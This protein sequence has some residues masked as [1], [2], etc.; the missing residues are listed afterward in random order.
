MLSASHDREGQPL[1]GHA[2]F[3]SER[4][5]CSGSLSSGT[6]LFSGLKL[7]KVSKMP[8]FGKVLKTGSPDA[9]LKALNGEL[10]LRFMQCLAAEVEASD[11]GLPARI[12]LAQL[13]GVKDA[14]VANLAHVAAEHARLTPTAPVA[15]STVAP[16]SVG[17]TATAGPT[18][19]VAA[20][21]SMLATP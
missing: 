7:D 12:A 4:S 15:S 1:F 21:T 17:S 9:Q 19:T 10:R 6:V 11:P 14:V 3:S 2:V 8:T 5:C 16:T 18:T 13:Q 20:A